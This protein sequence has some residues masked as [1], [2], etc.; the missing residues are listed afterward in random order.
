M[1]LTAKTLGLEVALVVTPPL[2]RIFLVALLT[3]PVFRLL[4]RGGA[5]GAV[6]AAG[7]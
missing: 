2:F 3:P 1:S 5:P 7:D 4:H 6:P